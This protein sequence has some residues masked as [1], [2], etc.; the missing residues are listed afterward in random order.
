[1]CLSNKF[2]VTLL[3]Q[4]PRPEKHHPHR[5]AASAPAGS[6]EQDG[7]PPLSLGC[8]SRRGL[9]APRGPTLPLPGP[10]RSWAHL[11]LSSEFAAAR[12]LLL[13]GLA[14][15]KPPSPSPHVAFCLVLFSLSPCV[16]SH[17]SLSARLSHA[18]FLWHLSI[19][20]IHLTVQIFTFLKPSVFSCF[21]LLQPNKDFPLESTHSETMG[22]GGWTLYRLE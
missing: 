5:G 8:I 14:T 12:P 13:P 17:P 2:P 16:S 15:P 11:S 21:L 9:P 18:G 7:S 4:G 20:F 19:V 3:A 1:M 22:R 10:E 6:L